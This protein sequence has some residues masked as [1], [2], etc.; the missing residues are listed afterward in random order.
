MPCGYILKV[1]HARYSSHMPGLK[2]GLQG[3]WLISVIIMPR[4]RRG[5]FRGSVNVSLQMLYDEVECR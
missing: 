4:M 5:F 2:L 3:C 1:F